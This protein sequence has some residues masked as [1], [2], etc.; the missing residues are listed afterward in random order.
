M[1]LQEKLDKIIEKYQK[2][3]DKLAVADNIGGKDYIAL[4]KELSDLEDVVEKIQEYNKVNQEVAE[5]KKILND[6]DDD[7]DFIAEAETEYKKL[8]ILLPEKEKQLKLSLIPKDKADSKNAIV[9]IRAGT[10]GDEAALFAG[11]LF[12]MYQRYASRNGWKFEV[13]SSSESEVGGFKEVS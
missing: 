6:S 12:Y 13:L 3:Q 4:T 11:V 5:L 9:E 10:G 7:K 1:S 2:L 8:K